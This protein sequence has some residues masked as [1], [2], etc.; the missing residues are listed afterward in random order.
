MFCENA[1]DE[2]VC[3][4]NIITKLIVLEGYNNLNHQQPNESV[5][6]SNYVLA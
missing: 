3:F 5:L 6:T 4:F 1:Y 2:T